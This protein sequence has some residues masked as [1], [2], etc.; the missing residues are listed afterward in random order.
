RRA[1][2]RAH[3]AL[4]PE[5]SGFAPASPLSPAK[6]GLSP[7]CTFSGSALSNTSI[8]RFIAYDPTASSDPSHYHAFHRAQ[9][10]VGPD[11]TANAVGGRDGDAAA[12][13]LGKRDRARRA[14]EVEQ[15]H[16]ALRA[17]PARV[18]ERVLGPLE[19]MV[20]AR[21]QRARAAAV[22]EE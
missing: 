1:L 11:R 16:D 3:C 7:A 9:L 15:H 21:A 6:L 12:A 2:G 10:E 4:L 14:G 17:V 5:T 8:E 22:P 19:R 18:D 13:K 20:R